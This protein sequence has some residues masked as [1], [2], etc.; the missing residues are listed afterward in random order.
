M[1]RPWRVA[2]ALRQLLDEVNLAAPGRSKASDGTIGDAAHA[3]RSSDHNPWIVDGSYGVV[4]AL[5]ITHDPSHGCDVD[6]L[7]ERLVVLKDKRIK[8]L[9]RNKKIMSGVGQSNP[10]WV[11][12]PYT[13]ANPHTKHIHIS[14]RSTKALYDDRAQW[15]I[16][17]VGPKRPLPDPTPEVP[18][19]EPPLLKKGSL[20]EWVKTLQ[21]LLNTMGAAPALKVDGQFGSATEKAVKDFQAAKKLVVDGK[22]GSYTWAELQ[23]KGK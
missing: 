13:G 2:E 8:Y 16:G 22:V 11:D 14:V 12:R 17:P 1:A 7:K 10:A 5:D 20:G 23:R 6:V 9:I 4:T 19:V 3:S 15:G 21:G 18:L